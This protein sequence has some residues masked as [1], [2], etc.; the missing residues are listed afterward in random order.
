MCDSMRLLTPYPSPLNYQKTLVSFFFYNENL[1]FID[2]NT[3]TSK[4]INQTAKNNRR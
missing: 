3:F 2:S 1:N 4:H